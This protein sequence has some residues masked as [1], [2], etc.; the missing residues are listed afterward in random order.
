MKKVVFFDIDGT[1]VSSQNHVPESTKRAIKALKHQGILP[2]IATGRA[3]VLLE[4]VRKELE[5]DSYI[6]MNGQL[7]VLEG[8]PIFTN[9]LP[10]DVL[11]RLMEKAAQDRK[12]I[13]LCGTEDIYSNSFVSLVKRSSVL[14]V[15][16]H[17]GKLIPNRIQMSLFSRLIRK[18]PKP[19]DFE[20]E[21]I[22][23]VLLELDKKEEVAY[24]N[25]FQ[26]LHFTRSNDYTADVISAGISKATG[27]DRIIQELGIDIQDT[28]AF[29][30]SLNDLEMIQ[31]VGTGVSMGNGWQELKQVAD[32]I[33]EDVS[34]DGIEIALKKLNLIP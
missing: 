16:K 12:G 13:V 1:L 32:M 19:E 5:I 26:E 21:D 27:I 20:G 9:P 29:G 2:V 6:A 3:T 31:H 4:E 17:I 18:P 28:Y 10:Q 22:C 8:V 11:S 33:T 34:E 25:Q 24:K 23:Q 30:D 14:S 15:L 7:V